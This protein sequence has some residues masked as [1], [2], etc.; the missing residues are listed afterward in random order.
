MPRKRKKIILVTGA[1]RGIGREIALRFARADF[2]VIVN[3]RV[4]K[5]A[6]DKTVLLITTHGGEAYSFKADVSSSRDV[7]RLFA[8]IKNKFNMLDVLVN[9]AGYTQYVPFKNNWKINEKEFTKLID[10]NL[11]S[12][13]LCSRQG[14][15]LLKKSRNGLIVNIASTSGINA[16]GSNV[17]YCAAKAGVISLTKS[18]ARASGPNV[19]VNA[20]APGYINTEF[21]RNRPQN[22][23]STAKRCALIHRLTEPADVAQCVMA[24]CSDLRTINGEVITVDGGALLAE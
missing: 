7:I 4:N 1:S 5:P 10:V 15:P 3:Y 6:A 21:I 2:V 19:R 11:K 20:I 23:L 16:R 13:F 18:F 8:Y 12:V 17:V 14:L 22:L 9:N 24:L